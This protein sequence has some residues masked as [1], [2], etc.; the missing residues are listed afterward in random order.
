[1]ENENYSVPVFFCQDKETKFEYTQLKGTEIHNFLGNLKD[2]D[3][4][5]NRCVT[6]GFRF[7]LWNDDKNQNISKHM[8]IVMVNPQTNRCLCGA[9]NFNECTQ[10]I[11][12]GKCKDSMILNKFLTNDKQR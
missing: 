11:A 1:M 4:T 12:V 7:V 3:K 5:R 10:N 2:Y 9:R 8:D 6:N